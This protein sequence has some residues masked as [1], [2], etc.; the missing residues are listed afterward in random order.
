MKLMERA[1]DRI[2]EE[3]VRLAAENDRL[4]A[5]IEVVEGERDRAQDEAAALRRRLPAAGS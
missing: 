1:H 2:L 5:R 3:N 4:H